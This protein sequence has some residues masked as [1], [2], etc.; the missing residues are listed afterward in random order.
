MAKRALPLARIVENFLIPMATP[1]V[2]VPCPENQKQR[3]IVETQ[4]R[5]DAQGI[6]YLAIDGI[7]VDVSSGWWLMRIS[8]TEPVLV[9]RAEA[10][11]PD[12]LETLWQTVSEYLQAAGLEPMAYHD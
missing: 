7:R 9:L 11:T 3:V 8:N 2:R 10:K 1:E 12:A 5:L 6:A 4:Q